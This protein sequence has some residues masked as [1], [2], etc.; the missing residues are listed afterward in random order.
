M[1][2][3]IHKFRRVNGE[4]VTLELVIDRAAVA[5]A[6]AE[7]ACRTGKVGIVKRLDGAIIAVVE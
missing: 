6:I 3:T 1:E 7:S 2:R 5:R 4:E